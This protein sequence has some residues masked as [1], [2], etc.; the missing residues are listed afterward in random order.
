[1]GIPIYLSTVDK[2]AQKIDSSEFDELADKI[3]L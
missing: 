2:K 3:I 1:M